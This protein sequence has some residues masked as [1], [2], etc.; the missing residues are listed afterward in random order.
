MSEVELRGDF[1][2]VSHVPERRRDGPPAPP[3]PANLLQKWRARALDDPNALDYWKARMLSLDVVERY[4]LGW[5]WARDWRWPDHER[6]NNDEWGG[7]CATFECRWPGREGVKPK[8]V[9][10]RRR[11]IKP[12]QGREKHKYLSLTN[13]PVTLFPD[14]PTGE[15]R[16]PY[17]ADRDRLDRA[18]LLI[19]TA[20][21]FDALLLRRLGWPSVSSTGG[22][23]YAWPRTWAERVARC[24]E[25]VVWLFDAGP[26]TEHY[27]YAH[28]ARFRDAGVGRQHIAEL[29]RVGVPPGEDVTWFAQEH[30]L[31]ALDEF[32]RVEVGR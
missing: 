5:C 24:Y 17:L 19:V 16:L 21:E 4:G 22:A 2:G 18:G 26:E 20:G 23:G 15:A 28:A 8:L 29:E 7:P 3:P 32:L 13:A 9:N 30:G 31:D 10:V 6:D 11:V 25:R 27:A 1:E 12:R 14:L